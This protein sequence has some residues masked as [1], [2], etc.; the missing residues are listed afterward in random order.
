MDHA[1]AGTLIGLAVD[2][3][4]RGSPLALAQLPGSE[5]VAEALALL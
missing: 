1:H 2:P 3:F 4:Q 5:T